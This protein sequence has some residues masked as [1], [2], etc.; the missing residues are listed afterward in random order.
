MAEKNPYREALE[1]HGKTARDE[2][3]LELLAIATRVG[4]EGFLTAWLVANMYDQG[5]RLPEKPAQRH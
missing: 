4:T 5:W 2:L 1:A 3:A